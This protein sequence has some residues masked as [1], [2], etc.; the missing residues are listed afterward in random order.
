MMR[1]K[2]GNE[3]ELGRA[4]RREFLKLLPLGAF[5]VFLFEEPQHWLLKRGLSFSDAVSQFA[6]RHGSKAQE[7]SNSEVADFQKF[8][9]NFWD[10]AD[11]GVDL[12]A[13]TLTVE[14]QVQRPGEYRLADLQRLP[15]HEQNTRHVCVEGWDVIGNF[16]GTRLSEVLAMV[17]ADTS[18]R[19]LYFECADNYYLSIDMASALHPQTL[20]CWEMYGRPLNRGH[21]APL[22]IVI[23]TKIGYKQPKYVEKMVVTN[24]L[25]PEHRG[26]WEDQGYSWFGGL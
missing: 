13:W 5:G 21:G 16:G 15:K 9:Y 12:D 19:Y 1:E 6:F 23:P 7:F 20:A 10:V 24:V 4:S 14:G 3:S 2:I 26:F 25:R 22:R 8:P 18:A 11:P 17:G